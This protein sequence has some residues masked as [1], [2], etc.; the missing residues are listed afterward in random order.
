M[1]ARCALCNIQVTDD[2]L[3]SFCDSYVCDICDPGYVKLPANHTL[4]DHQFVQGIDILCFDEYE[5]E[6]SKW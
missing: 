5:R 1:Q 4:L 2:F 3:C 6:K